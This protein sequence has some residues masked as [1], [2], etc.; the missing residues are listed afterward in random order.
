ML[1]AAVKQVVAK[2]VCV[3][4]NPQRGPSSAEKRE[5]GIMQYARELLSLGLFLDFHNAICEGDG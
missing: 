2:H 3:Q 4:F 1:Q 5:D